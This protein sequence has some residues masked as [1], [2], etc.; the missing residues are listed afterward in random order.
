MCVCW[1]ETDI[2]HE[3]IYFKATTIYLEFTSIYFKLLDFYGT[4]K[5]RKIKSLKW[6]CSH[7]T[8]HTYIIP[9]NLRHMKKLAFFSLWAWISIRKIE[10]HEKFDSKSLKLIAFMSQH[11]K[12]G[13]S[14]MLT[15]LKP[16]YAYCCWCRTWDFHYDLCVLPTP[17][18]WGKWICC[19]TL[20]SVNAN[21][22]ICLSQHFG[23]FK[24][25]CTKHAMHISLDMTES[26]HYWCEHKHTHTA[27][28]ST[29][30]TFIVDEFNVITQRWMSF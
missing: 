1:L 4:G 30:L 27:E 8:A 10:I 28:K 11:E 26:A 19:H 29:S 7:F 9:F 25:Q 23:T 16:V 24:R 12:V 17:V 5:A 6:K 20:S 18:W 13:K 21:K 2:T 3:N 22:F 14:T 15:E